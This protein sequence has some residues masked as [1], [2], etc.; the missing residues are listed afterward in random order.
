MIYDRG[1]ELDEALSERPRG[2]LRHVVDLQLLVDAPDVERTGSM[3]MSSWA[4]AWLYAISAIR[5]RGGG[6]RGSASIDVDAS[7]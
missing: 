2:G 4:A 6:C 1:K 3:L 5:Q 7:A